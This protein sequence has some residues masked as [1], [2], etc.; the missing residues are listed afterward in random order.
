MEDHFSSKMRTK[1]TQKVHRKNVSA[2]WTR[3]Y[4]LIMFA[5]WIAIN[6]WRGSRSECVCRG[7]KCVCE[8]FKTKNT[9]TSSV[10]RKRSGILVIRWAMI[11]W[12]LNWGP[13]AGILCFHYQAY[14]IKTNG[15][16]DRS[17]SVRFWCCSWK[18][19]EQFLWYARMSFEDRRSS[20]N[21]SYRSGRKS[22]WT[23]YYGINEWFVL[24]M[25]LEAK[26]QSRRRSRRWQMV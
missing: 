22:W 2:E 4:I 14:V 12:L 8:D 3:Y 20:C 5:L 6:V 1:S 21:V 25:V 16:V 7:L 15:L 11:K 23:V 18:T 26:E 19:I 24:C 9:L 13:I 10:D 17:R